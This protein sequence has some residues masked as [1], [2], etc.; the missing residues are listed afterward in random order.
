MIS[1]KEEFGRGSA[2][3]RA[4]RRGRAKKKKHREQKGKRARV[5]PRFR[6]KPGIKKNFSAAEIEE[7]ELKKGGPRSERGALQESKKK[8]AK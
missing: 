6:G 3:W 5:A 4:T 1:R 7:R 2:S 8:L